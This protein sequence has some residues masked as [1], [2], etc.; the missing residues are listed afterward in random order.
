[1]NYEAGIQTGSK[2]KQAL[3][4]A[5]SAEAKEKEGKQQR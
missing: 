5:H 3:L 1:L 4:F 2:D